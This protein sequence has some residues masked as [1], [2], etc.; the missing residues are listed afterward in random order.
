VRQAKP[1][2]IVLTGDLL[3]H[4]PRFASTLGR[5]VR[6]LSPLAKHGVSV[7]SGN[8]DY[9]AGIVQTLGVVEAGG[10]RVLTNEGL[11]IG[12]AQAGFA[13]LGVNDVRASRFNASDGPDVAR[14]VDSLP[15]LGGKLS[16]ARDLPR[17]LPCHTPVYFEE[18]QHHVA[19]QLS[20][21]TH[22]GQVNLLVR[23][24]DWVL[25]HGWV[26]G[27]YTEGASQLYVN[28]GFGTVGPP[29]R[30]GSAPE[31]SRIVLTV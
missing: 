21:H 14:A 18:A 24:A 13:L 17:V 26:A 15:R 3:D 5:F 9:Y 12:D 27:L 19:L 8:H 25:P 20:G 7:I 22:G 11:V 6:R 28:R 10:G 4:D 30:V 23:P 2:L 1:D 31:V 29:A 16:L